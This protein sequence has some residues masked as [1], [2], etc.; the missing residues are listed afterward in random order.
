MDANLIILNLI[1]AI[2]ISVIQYWNFHTA[3]HF[4]ESIE[5]KKRLYKLKCPK[6][7]KLSQKLTMC[8]PLA[9]YKLGGPFFSAC[10][11]GMLTFYKASLDLVVVLVT[12]F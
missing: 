5:R 12:D 11:D 10:R 6:N 8:L 2:G 1:L 9:A 7:L 4:L 3:I